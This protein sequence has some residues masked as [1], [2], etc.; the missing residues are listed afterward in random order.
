MRT[1]RSRVGEGKN[2]GDGLK[3][4]TRSRNKIGKG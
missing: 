4:G 2:V 1:E 3:I